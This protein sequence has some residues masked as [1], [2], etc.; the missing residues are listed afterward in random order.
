VGEI[1]N[2]TRGTDIIWL[3]LN[4]VFNSFCI[5]VGI[6]TIKQILKSKQQKGLCDNLTHKTK[7]EAGVFST[8]RVRNIARWQF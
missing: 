8:L 7:L 2:T 4:M 3:T 1:A 6:H 5:N